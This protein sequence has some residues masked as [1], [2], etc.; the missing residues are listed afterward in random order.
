[1]QSRVYTFVVLVLASGFIASCG[2]GVTHYF[3]GTERFKD[4]EGRKH[5]YD[6]GYWRF[7]GDGDVMSYYVKKPDELDGSS[8][9]KALVEGT[10]P[11]WLKV[12]SRS[13]DG[14]LTREPL[15]RWKIVFEEVGLGPRREAGA[16]AYDRQRNAPV[17]EHV[18]RVQAIVTN[19]SSGERFPVLPY[20][21]VIDE[22][23]D[24]PSGSVQQAHDDFIRNVG[25]TG[26]KYD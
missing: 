5:E 1:M 2:S 14:E 21:D 24:E 15:N 23:R 25:A 11:I 3:Y 18:K 10:A 13:G 8:V 22:R 12:D 9:P 6:A 19:A 16:V 4:S 26:T 20:Y 7:A 17:F